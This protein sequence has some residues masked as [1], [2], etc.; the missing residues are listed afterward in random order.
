MAARTALR[1]G[2]RGL[3]W[4]LIAL[5]AIILL[6][7]LWLGIV[8]DRSKPKLE[9]EIAAAELSA[10]VTVARDAEGV[11]VITG[12]TRADVA[13][14]LGYL[15]G[16]ERFFQIDTLRRVAAGELSALVGGAAAKLDRQNR[17][18]RFRARAR[19]TVAAMPPSERAFLDRYVAGVNR[20]LAE[21][22]ASPFEYAILRG[23]PEPWRPEDTVL[24][25]YAMYLNLQPSTPQLEL[26]R[27]RAEQRGGRAL[28]DL[29]YPQGTELDAPLDG[30]R[31]PETPLPERLPPMPVLP[32]Q[33]ET[34][35]LA[36][37]APVLGSNNWAVAG[38]L[39]T[40]GAA[41]VANDMHLGLPVPGT[42]YR[43][44]LIV[45]P[46]PGSA[47]RPLSIA[48]VTLPGGPTI[49]AGSNG[50]IAWGFTNSYIDTSDA[51]IVEPV[52]GRPGFYRTP[53]GP[54]P[55]RR[56]TER[57]CIG[58]ECEDM[59]VEETI[60]G[61]IVG[62]DAFGRTIAMRWTAH[63][64][65][66]IRLGAPAG[67]EGA[68]S[69]AE[70]LGIAHRSGIPHQN[71]VVGDR[72]GNV[73][74]TIIGR[75]P[76]RD[77]FDGRDAVSFAD[78]TRG[79]R[80]YLPPRE[81]PAFVNPPHGRIWTA[82]ARV[83]GGAD[84][85]KLGDGRYDTGLR[86]GR[87]RDLLFARNRFGPRDFLA[88]QLDDRNA[89]NDFW[90]PVLLAELDKRKGDPRFAAMIG[91]VQG[92]G[93]RA[94]PGSVGY[95][96]IDVF[97]TA[98]RNELHLAYLGA[99]EKPR[100]TYASNQ[101]EGS[102]RR[103]LR[104]RPPALVPPDHRSWDSVLA[105]ALD[106]VAK[107]VDK[108]GGDVAAFRWGEV[109]RAGVRHPLSGAIPGLAWLTDPKDVALP[110]DAVTVRAQRPGSGASERFAVS[111]GFEREGIFHM[112][113]GQSGHPWSPYYLAG[114]QAW[115]EGRPTP[116]L[117]GPARWTLRF[118]PSR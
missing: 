82:N 35:A 92:W 79:W 77:G 12:A 116:F 56:A 18:H 8:L 64:P 73:A 52:P 74:W 21:L 100:R 106:E 90:Q 3:K 108:A 24:A 104:E 38:P 32:R 55:I 14:A 62:K 36:G 54:R 89:R 7:L 113:G 2:W 91:P 96:L 5:L 71:L 28:A 76:A 66:A 102:L 45:R 115:V 13:Y 70:A 103:L 4:L 111:P 43:A 53:D 94:V 65:G 67:M 61:P 95:R 114:H 11:P 107:E 47:E 51:V 81:V 50:R 10:P 118:V 84:Y 110:G 9:G 101:S 72:A 30:S 27:A 49:V 19:R 39:S 20:G 78:G 80:G 25:V 98:I 83:M 86:A 60:W 93:G 23:K 75:V 26:D 40:S 16:Q 44:H 33:L 105:A 17:V 112:P 41:L 1:W 69:V 29:L 57:L 34:A 109:G 42:W 59:V 99:P 85:A 97:R 58:S 22:G 68:G 46:A 6:L 48:G 31:L 63:D 117:P 88:I 15:H 87:I 37:E